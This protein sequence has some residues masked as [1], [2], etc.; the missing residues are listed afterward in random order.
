MKTSD[1]F[2]EFVIDQ[3]R[4]LEAVRARKMFG[5]HGLYHGETFFGI[6]FR[7]QL[8]FKVHPATRDEYERRGMKP[9]CPKPGQTMKNYLEVPADVF[10]DPHELVVWAR[11][12]IG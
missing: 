11:A 7:G 3:L 4:G 10:E 1:G 9:F 5:G 6:L 8:F 2:K 12:A